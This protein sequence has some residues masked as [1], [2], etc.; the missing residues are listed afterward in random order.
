MTGGN[1]PPVKPLLFILTFLSTSNYSHIFPYSYP[2]LVQ[3]VDVYKSQ[4]SARAPK[5]L[6][7]NLVIHPMKVRERE[8]VC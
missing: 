8:Y 6:I 1:V 7:E 3:V 5:I 4:L 2:T